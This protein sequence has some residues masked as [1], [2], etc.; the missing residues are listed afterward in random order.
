MSQVKETSR[1]KSNGPQVPAK[2]PAALAERDDQRAARL[3]RRASNLAARAASPF[4]F[5][6]RFAEEMDRLFEDFGAATALHKPSLWARGR[7]LLRSGRLEAEWAPHIDVKEHDGRLIVRADLPGL[8]RDDIK[9]ELTDDTLT[10]HGER[11]QEKKEEREGYCYSE[12]SYGTFYRAIPL[13]EG[14]DATKVTADF[15]NG[16]LEVGIPSPPRPD[17]KARSVEIREKK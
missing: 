4:A 6:R 11:R 15:H 13:P 7:D 16:V 3:A 9:V 14:V 2:E 8:T 17:S 12:C 10:I 1:A 5:M